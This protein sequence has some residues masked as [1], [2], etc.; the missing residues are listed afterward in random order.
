MS[1]A[2]TETTPAGTSTAA[3]SPDPRAAPDTGEP[4][5]GATAGDE[6]APHR[7]SKRWLVEW[8]VVVVVAVVLAVVVRGFLLQ[9][10][11]VPST[12]M[13]PTLKPGDRIVVEKV[14]HSIHSG[15]IVVFARPPAESGKCGGGPVPDLVKRVIGLPGD[16]VEV[17]NDKV[18]LDGKVL[19]EPWLPAETSNSNPLTTDYGPYK[20]PAGDYFMMGDNRTSS[21]D[22]RTWGPVEG[23]TIV[24]KVVMVAWPLS[25]FH[26]F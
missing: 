11:Y 16:T 7:R 18:Y 3:V 10:Y 14:T 23:S 9:T 1:P 22:S 19:P 2:P 24:G 12:S 13:Y 25:R 20:V 4:A 8:G 21:C 6:P 5:A 17:R 26:F 15:D